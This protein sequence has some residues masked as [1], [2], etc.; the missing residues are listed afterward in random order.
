MQKFVP[1]LPLG[2]VVSQ[3]RTVTNFTCITSISHLK[4]DISTRSLKKI[5]SWLVVFC[6]FYDILKWQKIR[7]IFG[8]LCFITSGK[9]R[10][11]RRLIHL[12]SPYTAHIFF[13]SATRSFFPEVI[14]HNTVFPNIRRPVLISQFNGFQKY[15][16]GWSSYLR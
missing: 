5:S 2:S 6:D 13:E 11:R 1:F 4:G 16:N 10:T 14:K 7:S 12:M 8:I 15:R 9:E 3:N